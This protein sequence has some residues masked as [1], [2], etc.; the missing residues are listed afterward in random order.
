MKRPKGK[1]CHLHRKRF[2]FKSGITA[3]INRDKTTE[4]DKK[5]NNHRLKKI[6][7]RFPVLKCSIKTKTYKLQDTNHSECLLLLRTS[8]LAGMPEGAEMLPNI[9]HSCSHKAVHSSSAVHN[10]SIFSNSVE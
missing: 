10:F 6:Y 2:V 4:A 1:P 9:F 8:A 5:K 7:L 3:L